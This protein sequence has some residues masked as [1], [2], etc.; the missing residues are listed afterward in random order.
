MKNSFQALQASLEGKEQKI[1]LKKLNIPTLEKDE[2]LIKTEFSSL[3][4]KDALAV[5]GKGRILKS[6]PMI[7]GIDGAGTVIASKSKK[8]C[9]GD[10]VIITG[11]NFGEVDDGGYTEI[12]KTKADRVVPLPKGLSTREAMIYGTAGFTA[13]L[14]L[15][16][17]QNNG[18][19]P[20]MGKIIVSGASGGVGQFAVSFFKSS[21]Y[22]VTALSGKAELKKRLVSLGAD[23]VIDPKNLDLGKRP[24]ESVRWAGVVDN[25]GGELLAGLI[26]HTELWGNIA[27]VG[28]ASSHELHTTVMP[29]ILRGVSL[30]GI[31]SNNTSWPMREQIWQMLAK[32]LKPKKLDSFVSDEISLKDVIEK[33]NEMLDRKT[34]GRTLIKF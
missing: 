5:T 1:E 20:A 12:I 19:A 22:S 10:S 28:L 16:R 25:V 26:A 27:C 30:L 34:S 8:F 3:N 24:L 13:A 18:Q 17:M 11:T 7:P 21:G 6:Y 23:E 29:L 15:V 4:Y 9:D 32:D 33:S 2:V 14:C 31:S